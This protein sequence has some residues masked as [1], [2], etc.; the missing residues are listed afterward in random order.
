MDG[1]SFSVYWILI[2]FSSIII[3]KTKHCLHFGFRAGF[4]QPRLREYPITK[5]RTQNKDFENYFDISIKYFVAREMAK[6]GIREANDAIEMWAVRWFMRLPVGSEHGG[7]SWIDVKWRKL[8][9]FISNSKTFITTARHTIDRA[10]QMSKFHIERCLWNSQFLCDCIAAT[11]TLCI[12]RHFGRHIFVAFH[13][14][15][16]TVW[17]TKTDSN[18]N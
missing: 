12:K 13:F 18:L 2:G 16:Y 15:Q 8:Q 14:N 5:K 4:K 7:A 3:H 11:H 9:W 10:S 6:I 1:N 17:I